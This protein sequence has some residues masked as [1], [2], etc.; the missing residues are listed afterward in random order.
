VP[1]TLR[2]DLTGNAV[3]AITLEPA[4]GIPHAAP[5]GPIIAKGPI[6]L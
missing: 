3:L 6:H 1:A 5:T 2:P 4:A